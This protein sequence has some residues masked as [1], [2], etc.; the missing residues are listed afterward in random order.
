MPGEYSLI[1]HPG[2]MREAAG[3]M[4]SKRTLWTAATSWIPSSGVVNLLFQ[5]FG[6]GGSTCFLTI[7]WPVSGDGTGWPKASTPF[8]NCGHTMITPMPTPGAVVEMGRRQ[9]QCWVDGTFNEFVS[10]TLNMS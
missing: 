8:S 3:E 10:G 7:A 6:P 2:A 4:A 5:N 9:T 1:A